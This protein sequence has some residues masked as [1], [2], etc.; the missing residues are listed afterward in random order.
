LEK[1]SVDSSITSA[2]ERV[3]KGKVTYS[4]RQHTTAEAR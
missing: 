1:K 2:F 4:H 3:S